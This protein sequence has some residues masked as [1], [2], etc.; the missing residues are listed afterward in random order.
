MLKLETQWSSSGPL[1][2]LWHPTV[3]IVFT[4][5]P[6][7]CWSQHSKIKD[8]HQP[9]RNCCQRWVPSS[10]SCCFF[11]FEQQ[12]LAKGVAPACPLALFS[13]QISSLPMAT[14]NP[15]SQLLI[16]TAPAG[17]LLTG[18]KEDFIEQQQ[19]SGLGRLTPQD[20]PIQFGPVMQA[21]DWFR[22]ASPLGQR[23]RQLCRLRRQGGEGRLDFRLLPVDARVCVRH[24]RIPPGAKI[25]RCTRVALMARRQI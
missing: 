4:R 23:Q 24:L 2:G 6:G 22:L 12:D 17:C 15:V 5:K 10:K 13:Q 21:Y 1:P 11:F 18:V 9:W 14:C 8:V 7:D 19:T 16:G 20:L 3:W 25:V